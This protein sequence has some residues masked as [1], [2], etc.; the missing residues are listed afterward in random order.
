MEIV[1]RVSQG[2]SCKYVYTSNFSK[3]R[4]SF[5]REVSVIKLWESLVNYAVEPP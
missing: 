1:V 2:N 3:I 5:L 4:L